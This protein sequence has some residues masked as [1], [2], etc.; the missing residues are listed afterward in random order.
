[1]NICALSG[2]LRF[3]DKFWSQCHE[4]VF[5]K[6]PAEA[7]GNPAR[8]E[9]CAAFRLQKSEDYLT[10]NAGWVLLQNYR[11]KGIVYHLVTLADKYQKSASLGL[12]SGSY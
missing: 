8:S 11:A 6:P 12:A 3:P 2:L 9:T 10:N 4:I 7:L 1:M 5:L